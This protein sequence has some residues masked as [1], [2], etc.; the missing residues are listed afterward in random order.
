MSSTAAAAPNAG[1]PRAARRRNVTPGGTIGR[2]LEIIFRISGYV[3]WLAFW[4]LSLVR[5]P[6]PAR[7]FAGLLENL[8]ASFVKLGQHLSLRSDLFPPEYLD[9]LQKLQDN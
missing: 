5:S 4:R 6:S 7:R 1:R 2:F 3:L 9:E 8:G